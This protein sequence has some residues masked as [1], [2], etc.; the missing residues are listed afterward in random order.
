VQSEL[1]LPLARTVL[2]AAD[3][4]VLLFDPNEASWY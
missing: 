3:R 2:A 1:K 4:G